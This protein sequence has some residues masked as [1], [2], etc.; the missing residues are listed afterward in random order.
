MSSIVNLMIVTTSSEAL[1]KIY[2][3]TPVAVVRSGTASL[4]CAP[5]PQSSD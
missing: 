4:A 2:T 5:A 3:V 1:A